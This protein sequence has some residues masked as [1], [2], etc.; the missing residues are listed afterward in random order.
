MNKQEKKHSE[1]K[2]WIVSELKKASGDPALAVAYL[3]RLRW[4]ENEKDVICPKC[5]CEG[6]CI[7]LGDN[8]KTGQRNKRFLWY[9][10]D[11]HGQFTVRTNSVLEKS[12]IPLTEWCAAFGAICSGKNGV[13]AKEISRKCQITYKS[14]LFLMHRIRYAMSNPDDTDRLNGTVEVDETYIGGKPR[15]KNQGKRGRGTQKQPVLAIVQRDGNIKTSV[16][17]DVTG[18]TLKS[19]IRESVTKTSRVMTDEWASYQGIGKEFDGGHHVVCHNLG[20]YVRGDVYTNT[21]ESFFSILKRS[22]DGTYHSVSKKHL[23]RYLAEFGFRWD[24]HKNNDGERIAAAIRGIEG[25]RLMYLE[26]EVA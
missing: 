15:F 16:I 21:A 11:C 12:H 17:P 18:K 24:T 3:E 14:A 1:S 23:H 7:K 4:G 20:E 6:N 13:S 10:R 19:A 25:K 8:K 9:C 2:S 26:P 22:I 5:G